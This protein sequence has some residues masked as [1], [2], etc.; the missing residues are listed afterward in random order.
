MDVLDVD[1]WEIQVGD[2]L[3]EGRVVTET[4]VVF[5]PGSEWSDLAE[6]YDVRVTT[7]DVDFDRGER[8]DGTRAC[9]LSGRNRADS[10]YKHGDRVRVA[11]RAL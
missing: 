3:G 4:D 5:A 9:W 11:R 7:V 1:P 8:P 10:F 2:L 6:Q